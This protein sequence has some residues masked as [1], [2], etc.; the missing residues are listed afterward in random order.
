MRS[1]TSEAGVAGAALK[2]QGQ[3]G[4]RSSMCMTILPIDRSEKELV[5]LSGVR[6]SGAARQ[7]GSYDEV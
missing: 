7:A 6:N 5:P 2:R 1:S 3:R 4:Q